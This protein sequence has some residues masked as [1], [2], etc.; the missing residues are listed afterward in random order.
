VAQ[1]VLRSDILVSEATVAPLVL[2]VFLA[3]FQEVAVGEV[4]GKSTTVMVTVTMMEKI[5][6]GV[7]GLGFALVEV[8]VDANMVVVDTAVAG[9]VL[10]CM[11]EVAVGSILAA[12]MK[13][14]MVTGWEVAR[15]AE[16]PEVGVE[17]IGW[18]VVRMAEVP[19]VGV[20]VIGWEVVRMSEVV[21]EV[22]MV[23]VSSSGDEGMAAADMVVWE[24]EADESDTGGFVGKVANIAGTV[25]GVAHNPA[26]CKTV[27]MV[28]E[29]ARKFVE[30]HILAMR[31]DIVGGSSLSG[32]TKGNNQIALV[33][34]R[35]ET[36]ALGYEMVQ[37]EMRAG[38]AH[39][40]V[41]LL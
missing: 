10:E 22:S 3:G 26:A 8:E 1:L 30:G 9:E 17:V 37:W 33:L 29:V 14:D 21:V 20:E 5:E 38:N 39:P 13:E 31:V 16:V 32:Q 23:E 28:E 15:M 36:V 34:A 24:A 12:G 4:V 2:L 11:S 35:D 18:E 27:D 19:E 40:P 41:L 6:F 7:G 25:A